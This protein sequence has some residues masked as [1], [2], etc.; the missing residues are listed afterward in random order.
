VNTKYP[1]HDAQGRPLFQIGGGNAYRTHDCGEYQVSME[2]DET[3]PMMVIWSSKINRND[4]ALGICLS[5]IGKYATPEGTLNQEGANELA[6]CLPCFGKD[7]TKE[8]LNK[9]ADVV[10]RYTPELIA[11]PPKPRDVA[12][13]DLKRP[14]LEVEEISRDSGKRIREVTL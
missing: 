9:L 5:S 6:L 13:D 11:M 14:L 12:L 3:E 10:L 1:V 8:N 2:W 7:L 4:F